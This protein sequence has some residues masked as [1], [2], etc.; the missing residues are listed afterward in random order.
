MRRM[1][2]VGVVLLL[3][4]AAF[5]TP[6]SGQTRGSSRER[7]F[8]L[9]QNYPNPFN[10]E[11]RIPFILLPEMFEEGKPPVVVSL[12]IYNPLL[13]E[14]AI[15]TALRHASGAVKV[16]RLVYTEPGKHETYWDGKDKDGNKVQSGVYI[17][18]LV[19]NGIRTTGKMLVQN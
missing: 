19:V 3:A 16:D 18:Q 8:Q 12:T 10:P 2:G 4:L 14:V 11:T 9:E 1:F 15:P 7:G 17:Y 6:A 5:T 13:Q